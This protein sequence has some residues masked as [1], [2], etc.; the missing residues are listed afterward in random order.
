MLNSIDVA[1]NEINKLP[2]EITISTTTITC[3]INT[4]FDVRYIAKYIDLRRDAI[5][6]VNYGDTNNHVTNRTILI[7]KKKNR[8]KNKKRKRNFFNQVTL[9]VKTYD[10]V[11]NVKLFSN[12]SIQMT[13][14]K[15]ALYCTDVLIKITEELRKVKA[16]YDLMEDKIVDKPFVPD[17]TMIQ[18]E[19][20]YDV[21]ICMI[22]SNFS[23]GFSINRQNLYNIL[24]RDNITCVYEPQT[25]AGVNIKFEYK[26]KSKD[27]IISI[28]VFESGQIIITGAKS[29][30]QIIDSYNFINRYLLYNFKDIKKDNIKIESTIA[31]YLKEMEQASR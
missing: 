22:N 29:C 17:P 24:T 11:V 5:L 8:K 1:K 7:N 19:N 9:H 10:T 26:D 20:I 18:L 16:I 14:R 23:I 3:K 2:K 15:S 30:S 13:G 6:T 27:K 31:T 4:T 28:L 21:K 25:H 12:G